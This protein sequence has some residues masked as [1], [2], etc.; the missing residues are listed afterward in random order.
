[1]TDDTGPGG[2]GLRLSGT[3]LILAA[4]LAGMVITAMWSLS[5][6]HWTAHLDRA[7]R[8]G[9]LIYG[10]LSRGLAPPEGVSLTPLEGTDIARAE[11]GEFSQIS[12]L[13]RPAYVTLAPILPDG[14]GGSGL[15]LAVISDGL[16]FRVADLPSRPGQ[17]PEETLG[18]LTRLM[19]RYCSHPQIIA[20]PDTGDWQRV[21]APEV[22]GCEA[23]P[24]DLR[25]P[26]IG[27]ALLALAVIFTLVTNTAARFT[28]F[29]AALAARRRLGGPE[30]YAA[31]GPT[32]LRAIVGAV[33][34]YLEAERAQLAKRA[35][36]LSGVSHDLGTPATRLRLRTALIED[37]TLRARF[38]ADIDKMSA[39]IES[40]LTYTRAEL[41]VEAPREL[42][43]TALVEALVDDYRDMGQPVS[44]GTVEPVVLRGGQSLFTSRRGAQ[45][46]G[47]AHRVIVTA[48]PVSIQR[49]VSNL[50][51]NALKYGRRAEL[52]LEATAETAT[53]T[54]EDESGMR[55]T[56]EIEALMAPFRRGANAR[57]SDG[58][59]LG[60]SI[61][62]TIAM[63]HDGDLHFETAPHGLRAVFTIRRG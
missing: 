63:M 36:V 21:E 59:G 51:D 12:A 20:R 50:V 42:S 35:V 53:I 9:V 5:Q 24:A 7:E 61:V 54:V 37:D 22:W 10:A 13:P 23:A 47:G 29:A 17:R 2:L 56:E 28:D 32:E 1:M 15:Q 38:E 41:N 19:A 44:L 27:L 40:A 26:A 4:T 6:T 25:L 39:I 55:S 34:T 60:L 11:R 43:L 14:T 45:V 62:S 18:Q 58:I 30:S 33:N 3:L 16:Q 52:R 46:V 49:A 48:R 8:A 57:S 31:E